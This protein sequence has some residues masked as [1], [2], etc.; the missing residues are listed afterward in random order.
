MPL[1]SKKL[2]KGHAG[3]NGNMQDN[4]QQVKKGKPSSSIGTNEDLILQGLRILEKLAQNEH[5]CTQIYDTKGLL[6][7]ITAPF[8]SDKFI[9]D[10]R[11]SVPWI[12]VVEASLRVVARLM[13]APGDTGKN[14]RRQIAGNNNSKAIE[15]LAAVLSLQ[16]DSSTLELRT[17]A[18][19]V[20][21]KLFSD[22]CTNISRDRIGTF[23]DAVRDTLVADKW[24]ED[25]LKDKRT[26]VID[27]ATSRYEK[28]E[29][30][31]S[32]LEELCPCLLEKKN[33][34]RIKTLVAQKMKEAQEAA[35][36]HKEMAGEALAKE[37]PS[38][39]KEVTECG[40]VIHSLIEM[41][42]GKIETTIECSM[43]A[44]EALKTKIKTKTIRC[45]ISAVEVL[46]NLCAHS[47]VNETFKKTMLG[48]ILEELLSTN[49]EIESQAGSRSLRNCFRATSNDEENP[50]TM[51]N[52]QVPSRQ[53]PQQ[54]EARMLQAALLSLYATIRAKWTNDDDFANV[55]MNMVA[56][57][58]EKKIIDAMSEA[59]ETMAGLESCMLF[60]GVD[61]D[62][63]GV[64]APWS[65]GGSPTSHQ[66]SGL[67][68]SGDDGFVRGR[69]DPSFVGSS[70]M[71]MTSKQPRQE[72]KSIAF[73][74]RLAVQQWP[75]VPG[76]TFLL[77]LRYK[78]KIADRRSAEKS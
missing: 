18:T 9:E 24:M 43:G 21:A 20:L 36:R 42:D 45:R 28:D 19:E 53:N 77:A 38:G 71:K 27:E 57:I 70:V 15:N 1:V 67:V 2:R 56:E 22:V 62:C 8:N 16:G 7:K 23:T 6:L 34:K 78:S 44:T 11:T 31:P 64:P 5:N 30:V 47:M 17:H 50:Q 3:K 35:I 59:T 12:K 33:K 26:K 14:M 52:L 60:S 37:C 39:K 55:V 76:L 74:A 72:L 13:E 25:Y 32:Y 51:V 48:K 41:I 69:E 65:L 63:Y 58:K 61:H 29:E 54:P 49:R 10:I 46:K 75:G 73:V 68:W 4:K 40:G 66:P